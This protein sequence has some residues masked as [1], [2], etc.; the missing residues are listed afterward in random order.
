[1]MI[2]LP[3]MVE[4]S[5]RVVHGCGGQEKGGRKVVM[6]TSSRGGMEKMSRDGK[7]RPKGRRGRRRWYI[8]KRRVNRM[9]R[10]SDE[11][12]SFY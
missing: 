7:V 10:L 4:A 11:T 3:L 1:M 2:G 5:K 6:R 12:A 9:E 8:E